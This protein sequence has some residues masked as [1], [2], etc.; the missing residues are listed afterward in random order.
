MEDKELMSA[1]EGIINEAGKQLK[2]ESADNALQALEAMFAH[3]KAEDQFTSGQAWFIGLAEDNALFPDDLDGA[4]VMETDAT[5]MPY[6]QRMAVRCLST[7]TSA[8]AYI[9]MLSD[10]RFVIVEHQVLRPDGVFG[11]FTSENG[12]VTAVGLDTSGMAFIVETKTSRYAKAFSFGLDDQPDWEEMGTDA[13]TVEWIA[14]VMKAFM[15]PRMLISNSPHM[16]KAFLTGIAA[17]EQDILDAFGVTAEQ[18]LEG[19]N[20]I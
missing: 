2:G 13:Q 6:A 12:I 3:W 11:M 9:D 18:L 14:A 16:Y 7:P 5:D 10:P 1:L 20:G 8:S 19:L 15:A 17:G 4:Q